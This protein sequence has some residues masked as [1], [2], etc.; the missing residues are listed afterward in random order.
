M[1]ISISSAFDAGNINVVRCNAPDDIEL[2]IPKDDNAEFAQWFYFRLNGAGGQDCTVRITG[3]KDSA[4]P[5]GWPGYRAVVSE[6]RLMWTRA[7]TDYDEASGALTIHVTPQSN[8]LWVSYFAPYS[9]EQHH[10]LIAGVGEADGVK[11]ESLGKTLDGQDMDLVTMG[12]GPLKLWIIARQHPGESMGEW[13][14]EGALAALTDPADPVARALREKATLYIVPNMNPDGSRRGN[15]RVNGVGANL[16]REWAEPS[17]DR[18][19]EVFLVRGKMDEVGCDFCLDVH[20]DEAIANNFIAGGE[21]VPRFDARAQELLDGWK[22]ALLIRSP[23]FQTRQGYPIDK[24]GSANLAICTNQMAERFGCLAMTLEM[25]FKDAAV[26]PDEEHG[27]SPTR[28]MRL[29]EACLAATLAM[30][31]ELQK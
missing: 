24:P 17:L 5:A 11:I 27:W 28:C 2:T 19:P 26:L 13:W 4:Y 9:M 21:G 1:T 3:L 6:D 10:D 31:D 14:M 18:S 16:N 30:A 7:D 23:D 29:A 20:G 25:P 12:M 15:L 8:G 22:A